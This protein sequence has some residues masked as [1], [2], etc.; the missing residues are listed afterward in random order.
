[1]IFLVIL[2]S[3]VGGWEYEKI[4][5]SLDDCINDYRHHAFDFEF[6]FG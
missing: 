4:F 1:M 3:S 2:L 5:E 6:H